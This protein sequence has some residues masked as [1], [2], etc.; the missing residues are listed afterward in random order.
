MGSITAVRVG[1]T[2]EMSRGDDDDPKPPGDRHIAIP[3]YRAPAA[4]GPRHRPPS[5]G[6]GRTGS[7]PDVAPTRKVSAPPRAVSS[8]PRPM[9]SPPRPVSSPPRSR[10]PAALASDAPNAVE[11]RGIEALQA[12]VARDDVRMLAHQIATAEPVERRPAP[13]T[14][15]TPGAWIRWRPHLTAALLAVGLLVIALPA[16]STYRYR[17]DAARLPGAMAAA[18]RVVGEASAPGEVASWIRERD[19]ESLRTFYG[20]QRPVVVEQL[21]AAGFDVDEEDVTIRVDYGAETLIIGAQVDLGRDERVFVSADLAARPL[22]RTMP[23]PTIASSVGEHSVVVAGVLVL[24]AL[25]LGAMWGGP[26]LRARA[27][28]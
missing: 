7:L 18:A 15:Y 14:P 9:S 10:A 11:P 8:P 25:L 23:P 21:T 20:K 17:S 2:V 3:G 13:S 12:E 6:R 19:L 1:G 28:R 24:L 5:V 4:S 27:G 16:V 22:G 26:A